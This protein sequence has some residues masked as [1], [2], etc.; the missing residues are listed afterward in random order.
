MHA[1]N[2]TEATPS[3]FADILG[4]RREEMAWPTTD[5]TALRICST[6]GAPIGPSRASP[7]SAGG[8]PGA[9]PAGSGPGR[10]RQAA[11]SSRQPR[12]AGARRWPGPPPSPGRRGPVPTGPRRSAG[13][14]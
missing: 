11:G 9:G 2:G 10:S 7:R 6:A 8:P 5:N 12:C 3:L 4:D 13:G 14:G 1:D